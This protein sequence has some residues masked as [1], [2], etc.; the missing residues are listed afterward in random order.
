MTDD[1]RIYVD[2]NWLATLN[3]GAGVPT[4]FATLQEANWPGAAWATRIAANI[5]KLPEREEVALARLYKA[6]VE[7]LG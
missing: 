3:D 6:L 1:Y 7:N 4:D 5:A 2:E